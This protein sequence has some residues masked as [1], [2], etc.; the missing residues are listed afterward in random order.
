MIDGTWSG[1]IAA[2]PGGRLGLPGF[3]I[4]ELILTESARG[5]SLGRDLSPLLAQAL[6]ASDGC[7]PT[8]TDPLESVV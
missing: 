5:H 2:R 3:T 7:S 8:T 4:Q 6:P 1:Y